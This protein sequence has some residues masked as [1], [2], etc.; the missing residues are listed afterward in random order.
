MV[1]LTA[2]CS[3]SQAVVASSSLDSLSDSVGKFSLSKNESNN[4]SISLSSVEYR[5][6]KNDLNVLLISAFLVTRPLTKEL[7]DGML[8]WFSYRFNVK[9]RR[10]LG[11]LQSV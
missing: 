2:V 10:R 6:S 1:N 5:F 8:N 3:S 4:S 7:I 9:A 11:L